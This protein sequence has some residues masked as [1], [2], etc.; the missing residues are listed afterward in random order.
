MKKRSKD[1]EKEKGSIVRSDAEIL[2]ER[3]RL[4]TFDSAD[5]FLLCFAWGLWALAGIWFLQISDAEDADASSP[6]H[7]GPCDT[8]LS[9]LVCGLFCRGISQATPRCWSWWRRSFHIGCAVLAAVLGIFFF[10]GTSKKISMATYVGIVSGVVLVAAIWKFPPSGPDPAK[11]P[12]APVGRFLFILD[13]LGLFVAGA[14]VSTGHDLG[15]NFTTLT[16]A[17]TAGPLILCSA[18]MCLVCAEAELL[19]AVVVAMTMYLGAFFRCLYLFG[20]ATASPLVLLLV[21]HG[22]LF[23]PLPLQD[24]DSNV[25]HTALRKSWRKSIRFLTSPVSGFGDSSED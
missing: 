3:Q 2:Q 18:G 24:P 16:A 25:F 19:V 12:S 10:F 17:V 9:L 4:D 15:Q 11:V 7:H 21:V 8:T 23:L 6:E 1:K 13:G 14:C 20:F 5:S 22:A